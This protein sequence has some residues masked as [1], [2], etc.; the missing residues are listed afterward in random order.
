MR[1]LHQDGKLFLSESEEERLEL[2]PRADNRFLL[3]VFP[4]EFTFDQVAP[5]ALWVAAPAV[6]TNRLFSPPAQLS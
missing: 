6:L 1:I 5:G 2:A 4:V 3:V